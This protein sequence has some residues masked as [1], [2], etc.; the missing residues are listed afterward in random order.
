MLHN[1]QVMAGGLASSVVSHLQIW[2][3]WAV[4]IATLL[5]A[6][7]GAAWWVPIAVAFIINPEPYGFVAGLIHGRHESLYPAAIFTLSQL[8][9][10]FAGFL[11]GRMLNGGLP[12]TGWSR[13]IKARRRS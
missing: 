7:R 10:A 4:L 3:G 6:W 1:L 5:L 9:L 8:V 13:G 12:R 11:V 2:E